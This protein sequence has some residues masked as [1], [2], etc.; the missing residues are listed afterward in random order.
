M[1]T[2]LIPTLQAVFLRATMPMMEVYYIFKKILSTQ[3]L[4]TVQQLI[5]LPNN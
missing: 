3:I 5:T 2:Q 1:P 4:Q